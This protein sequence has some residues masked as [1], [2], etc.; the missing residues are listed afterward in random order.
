MSILGA[1]LYH[2]PLKYTLNSAIPTS[3][4]SLF[5]LYPKTQ[6]N[7]C[8]QF[9]SQSLFSH[10]PPIHHGFWNRSKRTHSH[11]SRCHHYNIVII[12]VLTSCSS[13]MSHATLTLFH[14]AFRLIFFKLFNITGTLVATN[15]ILRSLK[16]T[17]VQLREV[18][19]L[20]HIYRP[21]SIPLA[22]PML[23]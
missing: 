18:P 17:G 9:K 5:L 6:W 2:I 11:T 15:V 12:A 1:P 14:C 13:I 7:G 20:G 8:P 4:M 23:T 19:E 21:R 10:V 16:C 3:L 22:F